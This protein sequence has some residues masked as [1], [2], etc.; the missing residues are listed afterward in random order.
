M[1][2]EEDL[3][4]VENK[5]KKPNERM[6]DYNKLEEL[7]ITANCYLYNL[8]KFEFKEPFDDKLKYNRICVL[9]PKKSGKT[10]LISQLYYN[11]DT[12]YYKKNSSFLKLIDNKILFE[13][14]N[15]RPNKSKLKYYATH[16]NVIIYVV[17]NYG[18]KQQLEVNQ[19]IKLLDETKIII[20]VH[21]GLDIT[22]LGHLQNFHKFTG[23][24][25]NVPRM[26]TDSYNV[27]EFRSHTFNEKKSNNEARI[28]HF[29]LRRHLTTNQDINDGWNHNSQV[30]NDMQYLI[31]NFM[32]FG[33]KY[34]EYTDEQ[35]NNVIVPH[36]TT[37]FINNKLEISVDLPGATDV[38]D[39][40]KFDPDT[41]QFTFSLEAKKQSDPVEGTYIVEKIEKGDYKLN[42]KLQY[43][44]YP[45]I[46][47][48][49]TKE[50]QRGRYKFIFDLLV[51]GT[52]TFKNN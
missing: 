43:L 39:E 31:G 33:D 20:I 11:F 25:E 2:N 16:C 44:K 7:I 29:F 1:M 50:H 12:K 38:K 49:P 45:I 18:Y 27:Q 22:N 37:K 40:I 8:P 32:G 14:P 42:I 24:L 26:N 3:K 35:N 4:K 13:E 34:E 21:N 36:Y 9:G 15:E 47:M 10:F 46:S 30:F 52:E 48:E 51:T 17:K 5:E 6:E 23:F 19:I 41:Q 28:Y